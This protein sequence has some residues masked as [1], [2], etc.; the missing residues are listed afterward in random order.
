MERASA[1]RIGRGLDRNGRDRTDQ[2]AAAL[3]SLDRMHRLVP[4]DAE[5]AALRVAVITEYMPYARHL[6]ARYGVRGQAEED[7]LQAAYIGL[8]KAVDHFDPDFGTAFLA[9]AT[10]TILGELKRYFRDTTWAVHVPR[11]VQELTGELRD[12]TETLSQ[13]LHRAPTV[14]EL[15]VPL[16]VDPAAVADAIEATGLHALASLDVPTVVEDGG[17]SPLSDL[18]GADDRGIQNVIDRETLRPLLATL[19]EREK[20]IVLMRFFRG[21]TQTEISKE[22]GVSQMQVS[23]LLAQILGRLRAHAG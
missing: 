6:A 12:A 15:A 1:P 19:S 11:R 7:F 2:R 20:K 18:L 13:R 9:F 3:R 22:L 17:G 10:P 21:M 23:R 5:R 4:G 14:R 16:G 8:V